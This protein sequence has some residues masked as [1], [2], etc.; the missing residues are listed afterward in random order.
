MDSGDKIAFKLAERL[1]AGERG[2]FQLH[3]SMLLEK[4]SI[5]NSNDEMYRSIL[6]DDHVHLTISQPVRD[7]IIALLC[8]EI[9][10]NPSEALISAV[11]FTG[12]TLATRTVAMVVADPPRPLTLS[13]S[14]YA[15]SLL[16]KFLWLCLR[17]DPA[18]LPEPALKRIVELAKEFKNL[19]ADGD[20][21]EKSL[22]SEMN[23]HAEG[24]IKGLGNVGIT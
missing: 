2:D 17:D 14:S 11:S 9:S 15:F 12:A 13:E 16:H 19:P 5:I 24:I 20:A 4:S 7:E 21:A 10:V 23:H 6:P 22:K 3:L 8:R 1:L 18:F